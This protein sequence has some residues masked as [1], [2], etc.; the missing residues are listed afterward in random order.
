MIKMNEKV[1]NAIKLSKKCS[2]NRKKS[3]FR[4]VF[5]SLKSEMSGQEFKDLCREGWD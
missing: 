2:K 4:D 3:D 1:L 5:G